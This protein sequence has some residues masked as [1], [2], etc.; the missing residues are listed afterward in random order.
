MTHLRVQWGFVK[1]NADDAGLETA[2]GGPLAFAVVAFAPFVA[3]VGAVAPF[4]AATVAA[5]LTSE[6]D[7]LLFDGDDDLSLKNKETF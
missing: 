3:V 1:S 2:V 7:C 5:A 4:A 6:I